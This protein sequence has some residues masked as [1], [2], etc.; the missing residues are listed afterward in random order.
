MTVATVVMGRAY[1]DISRWW[2]KDSDGEPLS[3]YAVHQKI[4]GTANEVSRHTLTRARDGLLEKADI[5]N[6][7]ALARLCSAW[8]GKTVTVDDLIVEEED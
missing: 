1:V 4:L 2:L 8:C 5:S 3:V 7:K 6:L